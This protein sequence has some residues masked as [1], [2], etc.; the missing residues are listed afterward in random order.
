MACTFVRGPPPPP[1]P[2]PRQGGGGGPPPPGPPPQA[3]EGEER[4]PPSRTSGRGRDAS[5]PARDRRTGPLL[6]LDVFLLVCV[7]ASLATGFRL[8][9]ARVLPRWKSARRPCDG[10]LPRPRARRPR[11]PCGS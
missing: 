9:R 6:P 2:R 10:S 7:S 1:T 3:G 8:R 11:L 5:G 4:P